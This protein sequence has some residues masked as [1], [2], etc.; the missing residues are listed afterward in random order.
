MAAFCKNN[1]I[2]ILFV[3]NPP[4][5]DISYKAKF[6]SIVP[7]LQSANIPYL[8]LYPVMVRDLSQYRPHQ[9]RANPANAH[10][11]PLVTEVYAREVFTY[12]NNNH[13]SRLKN[14]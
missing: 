11:G 6:N 5:C 12:L 3:N 8:D 7:L 9:L 14:H 13:L 2:E 10:P 4:N 1:D